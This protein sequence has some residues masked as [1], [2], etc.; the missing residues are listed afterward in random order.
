MT[1]AHTGRVASGLG[2]GSPK[3]TESSSSK[4]GVLVACQGFS[5]VGLQSEK[6]LHCV[7]HPAQEETEICLGEACPWY[8]LEPPSS[9]S[10]CSVQQVLVTLPAAR[11]TGHGPGD[12]CWP[13]GGRGVAAGPGL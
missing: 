9:P 1:P 2:T 4:E 12:L 7:L 3:P 5:S 8:V 13:L 11:E 6:G 10:S